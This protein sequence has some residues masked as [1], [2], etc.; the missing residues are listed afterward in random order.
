MSSLDLYNETLQIC[1]SYIFS[2][3]R[4]LTIFFTCT[5]SVAGNTFKN[6]YEKKE[7]ELNK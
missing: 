4:M 2:A 6:K 1:A 7:F 5:F 3:L